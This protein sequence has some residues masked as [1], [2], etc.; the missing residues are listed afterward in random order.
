MDRS[1]YVAN[2]RKLTTLLKLKKYVSTVLLSSSVQNNTKYKFE[3][4]VYNKM[5]IGQKK[6]IET[7]QCMHLQG[8]FKINMVGPTRVH[9]MKKTHGHRARG[10]CQPVREFR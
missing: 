5:L 8:K 10:G 9:M 1:R 2:L 6:T 3:F 4:R 7:E